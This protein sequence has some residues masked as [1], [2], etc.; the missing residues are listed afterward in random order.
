M[1]LG[2]AT[3]RWPWRRV[4]ARRLFPKREILPPAWRDLY[5]RNWLTPAL[6]SNTRHRLRQAY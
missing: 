2:L 3:E 5:C 6:P 1:R 4:L